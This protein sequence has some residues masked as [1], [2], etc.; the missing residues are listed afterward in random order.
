MP[1]SLTTA[2]LHV[3][4]FNSLGIKEHRLYK[5]P[6]ALHNVITK[7]RADHPAHIAYTVGTFQ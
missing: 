2:P 5:K 7:L 3:Y 6:H 4:V 1:L